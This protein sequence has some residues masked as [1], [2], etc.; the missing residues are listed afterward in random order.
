MI[1]GI[2]YGLYLKISIAIF[3][4]LLI[5]SLIAIIKNKKIIKTLYKRR[6]VISVLLISMIIF[7]S[8]TI[9]LNNK[10]EKFYK[11]MGTMI[12]I[13]AVVIS[14]PEA[15]DY[16]NQYQ[17]KS[18]N[19]KFILYTANKNLKYGMRIKVEGDFLKPE[20]KRNYKGF[21]YKQYLKTQKIYG[22]IKSNSIEILSENN[23][24]IIL[25]ASNKVRNKIIE[26][27]NQIL[28]DE[29]QALLPGILIGEKGEIQEDITK[30]FRDSS[31]S[32]IL[33]TS[34]THIT[35]IILGITYVFL[36]SKIPKRSSYFL[37]N[38]IL[39]FFMFIVGFSTSVVR[40]SIMGILLISSKIVYRKPDVLTSM[41]FSL[42]ITLTYNPFSIQ[43]IG[44]EL[45]YL[46]TLGIITLNKPIT[47]YLIEKIP[48]S[49][50]IIEMIS[51][52]IS[53]QILIIPIMLLR[54]NSISLTFLLS[55]VI[56]VPLAGVI[57]L[58]GYINIFMGIF[59]IKFARVFAV[60]LNILLKILI[61]ISKVV[62][63]IPFSKILIPTPSIIHIILYYLIILNYSRKKYRNL[64]IVLL[65]ISIL[66]SLIY[67][68]LPKKLEIHVIDVGQGDSELIITPKR[69]K[70]LIDGGE[71]EN[72]LLEY[73]LDRQIMKLEYVLISHFDSDHC[74]NLVEVLE[75]LQVDN[76]IISK[77]I[78]KTELFEKIIK[79]C[80]EKNVNIIVVEAGDEIEV[81]KELKIKILW[82][83]KNIDENSSMNDNSI[84]AKLEYNNFSMLFTGDIEEKVENK[85]I[86][87]YSENML[88][89][90][91]LKVAHHGSVSSSSQLII[92]KIMP[93]ISVIGVGSGNKFGHPNVEVIKRL[94]EC[95]SKI[96]RTD[97]NGEITIKVDKKGKI[98]INCMNM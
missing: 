90:T 58:Y 22:S 82:P 54:L 94:E 6:K 85:L 13:E 35:Y 14:E 91:A 86:E 9:I 53:G 76:L 44:F 11:E 67:N 48:I 32:H 1:I 74:Y 52:T 68:L 2:I 20:G 71:K 49:Q 26:I 4:I 93:E 30:D 33:A 36:K 79:I 27:S 65:I 29:T 81:E 64:F 70:I 77:Q 60:I 92:N 62:A 45:S 66:F 7:S 3:F 28:P 57:I 89:S 97:L 17:I 34:G 47:Q 42:I 37:I 12:D 75:N 15:G 73:L 61:M 51:V 31:L 23:V 16:Y 88:E 38:L 72:V 21:D 87:M 56:A 63:K 96:F 69:K 10:Y 83:I 8:Y 80:E 43:D 24:N 50:K 19:K 55:N 78:Q 98:K 40:A 39:I 41:A 95:K 46:G 25:K 59:S 84:V 18:E 5:A